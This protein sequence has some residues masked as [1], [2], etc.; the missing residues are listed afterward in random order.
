MG[1][2]F[3][4]RAG[5]FGDDGYR[6]DFVQ[7]DDNDIHHLEGYHVGEEGTEGDMP[8]GED[9][10]V[11]EEDED[12]DEQYYLA[13][14]K[15]PLSVDDDGEDFGSVE[16][17]PVPDDQSGSDAQD[18]TADE[19][20]LEDIRFEGREAVEQGEKE[21]KEDDGDDHLYEERA[22]YMLV[23]EI[24]EGKSEDDEV[25]GKQGFRGKLGEDHGDSDDA[26]IDQL[27]R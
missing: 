22:S 13:D 10:S 4:E 3:C 19:D 9:F 26:A 2:D 17:T 7:T 8:I 21:G 24:G 20:D 6:F 15:T 12:I 11:S 1:D 14:G 27:V 18:G 23:G 25:E 5:F 16:T